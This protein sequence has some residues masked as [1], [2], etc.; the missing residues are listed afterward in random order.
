[1]EKIRS[2]KMGFH[3]GVKVKINANGIS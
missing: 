3:L 1:M 2:F